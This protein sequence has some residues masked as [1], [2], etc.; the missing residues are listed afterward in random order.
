MRSAD[1]KDGLLSVTLVREMPE[2]MKPRKI[3]VGGGADRRAIEGDDTRSHDRRR[4]PARLNGRPRFR[5][6]ARPRAW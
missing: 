3:D 6:M 2:A 1:L 5:H 4:S